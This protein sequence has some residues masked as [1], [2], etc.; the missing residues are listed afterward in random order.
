[1]ISMDWNTMKG[2]DNKEYPLTRSWRKLLADL[3]PSTRKLVLQWSYKLI[4]SYEFYMNIFVKEKDVALIWEQNELPS[5]KG[6]WE[7]ENNVLFTAQLQLQLHNVKKTWF[8][9]ICKQLILY[10]ILTTA[11]SMAL[12]KLII[13]GRSNGK[14][15][16]SS[17]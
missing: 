12:Q 13:I 5:H 8:Y 17:C 10:I 7:I 15:F 6:S 9:A 14:I 2:L 16:C 3:L 4:K 1:M 11:G